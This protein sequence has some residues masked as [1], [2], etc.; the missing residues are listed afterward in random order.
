MSLRR[1]P[2]LLAALALG[3]THARSVA[4]ARDP[5]SRGALAVKEIVA[6]LRGPVVPCESRECL[7]E[8]FARCEPS[9]WA[10]SQMTLVDTPVWRDFLVELTGAGC[11]L[12][13]VEDH[14]ADHQGRCALTRQECASFE[15]AFQDD[16]EGHGCEGKRVVF[17]VEPCGAGRR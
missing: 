6:E 4:P 10:D 8:A 15:A 12:V 11:R 17:E 1:A 14:T 5:S 7:E 9:R 2:F 3:C 16:R 13:V